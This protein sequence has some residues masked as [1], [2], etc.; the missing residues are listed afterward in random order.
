MIITTIVA[1]VLIF[2]ALSTAML[3]FS[4]RDDVAERREEASSLQTDRI[5]EE[6]ATVYL[7][8]PDTGPLNGTD[9]LTVENRGPNQVNV[10]GLM[11]RCDD[12]RT[13]E[14]PYRM[15]VGGKSVFSAN[16]TDAA[17]RAL[18]G[19][20]TQALKGLEARC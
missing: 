1:I 3:Y 14:A 12:G 5:R 6:V 2:M 7:K 15:S 10:I 8:R 16:A 18:V 11:V 17:T 4:H 20:F 9:T 13:H 19:N